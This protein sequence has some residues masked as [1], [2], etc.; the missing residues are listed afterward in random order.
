MCSSNRNN[1]KIEKILSENLKIKNS[2]GKIKGNS[3]SQN[4]FDNINKNYYNNDLNPR[5]IIS[6]NPNDNKLKYYND[7]KIKLKQ[8]KIKNI[9]SSI[10]LNDLEENEIRKEDGLSEETE[11]EYNLIE[12]DN[13]NCVLNTVESPNII[14][15]SNINKNG[16]NEN[17]EINREKNL[18]NTTFR[19]GQDI[20][21]RK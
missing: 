10:K 19:G 14:K 21:E 1:E 18:S 4:N 12:V 9:H 13:A 2:K 11:K 5:L 20:N 16:R 17:I 7:E 8:N 6:N 3:K 15:N